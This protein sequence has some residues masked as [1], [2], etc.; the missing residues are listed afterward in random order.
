MQPEIMAYLEKLLPLLQRQGFVLSDEKPIN[1]GVQ[2]KLEKKGN[3]IPLSIYYSTKKGISTVVGGSPKNPL[4]R[5]LNE[6][7]LLPQEEIEL[8]HQWQKWI[9][10]DESGKGD[11][12]GPLITAGF[13]GEIH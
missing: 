10:T 6:M 9:G 12:F 11:F 8:D 3:E 5:Q 7:L 1:Y 2:L 4:R 13:Y